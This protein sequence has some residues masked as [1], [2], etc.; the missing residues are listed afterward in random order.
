MSQTLPLTI[1]EAATAL[2][3]GSLSSVRLTQGLLDRISELNDDLG[4]FV[5]VCGESALKAAES[6]DRDLASGMGRG[7]QGSP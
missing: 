2:R 3:A 6:V 1:E 5:T 7:C 4:A